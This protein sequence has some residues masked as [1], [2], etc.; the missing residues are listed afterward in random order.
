MENAAPPSDIAATAVGALVG[1]APTGV[2]V[3]GAGVAVESGVAAGTAV[4]TTT[5]LVGMI[6]S[7]PILRSDAFVSV[8]LR[9][10][11]STV[12]SKRRAMAISVS[13]ASTR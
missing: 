4:A 12:V 8:F 6:R 11:A 5:A 13:P 9:M 1:A 3:R 7:W 2:G 10:I